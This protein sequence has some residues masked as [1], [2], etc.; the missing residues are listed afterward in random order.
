V[1]LEKGTKNERERKRWDGVA[2]IKRTGPRKEG[3]KEE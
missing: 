3:K 1:K 2:E